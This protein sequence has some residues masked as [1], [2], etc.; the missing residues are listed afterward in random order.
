MKHRFLPPFFKISFISMPS[1]LPCVNEIKG[2]NTKYTKGLVPPFL[3]FFLCLSPSQ[4]SSIL[5]PG[6]VASFVVIIVV[7][8]VVTR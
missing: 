6:D 8:D 5:R 7:V 3:S 1:P 4:R 2:T